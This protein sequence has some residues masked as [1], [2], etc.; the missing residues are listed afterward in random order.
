M[1]GQFILLTPE[2]QAA[3]RIEPNSS[4]IPSVTRY[5]ELRYPNLNFCISIPQ[6]KTH[7]L[8]RIQH[9]WTLSPLICGAHS[10][11]ALN[12][13]LAFTSHLL[14]SFFSIWWDSQHI[15]ALQKARSSELIEK[16]AQGW[17]GT[18]FYCILFEMTSLAN[19][20]RHLSR[21]NSVWDKR[22][23]LVYVP[24]FCFSI[25]RNTRRVGSS[26]HS[27]TTPWSG[28]VSGR[29][30]NFRPAHA[31]PNVTCHK[32][33]SLAQNDESARMACRRDSLTVMY[34]R[35]GQ[36]I[37]PL[38][39]W[40]IHGVHSKHVASILTPTPPYATPV[41]WESRN[42]RLI[43]RQSTYGNIEEPIP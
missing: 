39:M 38:C 14:R 30:P 29:K 12:S 41:H 5:L 16:E 34:T 21:T 43:G 37:F 4:A 11:P 26:G 35:E 22:H 32:Y 24:I 27:P 2:L 33:L 28:S 25:K 8:R 42:I 31:E 19:F 9:A 10:I 6:C 23:F 36:L 13:I 7:S 1:F 18:N 20:F 3:S 15:S 17:D 40:Q